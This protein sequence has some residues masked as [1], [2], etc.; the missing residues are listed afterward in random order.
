MRKLKL[1]IASIALLACG[2]EAGTIIYKPNKESEPLQVSN[3]KII[4]IEGGVI[5]MEINGGKERIRVNQL[6]GYYDTDLKT[7]SG[8]DDNTSDYAISV[9]E[10]NVPK[11]AEEKSGKTKSVQYFEFSY[12]ISPKYEK[13]RNQNA[14]KQPYFYLYVMTEGS[15]NIGERPIVLISYPKDASVRAK[16]YDRAAILEKVNSSK[17][18]NMHFNRGTGGGL[19]RGWGREIKIPLNRIRNKDRNI[20]AWRLEVWGK[21]DMIYEKTWTEPGSRISTNWWTKMQ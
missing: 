3:V 14:V 15:S 21:T 9:M 18:Q 10:R 5:T 6:T 19:S 12:T 4:S 16:G 7:G 8:F 2:V 17:R 20:I 11:R 13:D 1:L